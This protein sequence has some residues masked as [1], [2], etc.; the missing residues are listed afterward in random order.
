MY[1]DFLSY[2]HIEVVHEWPSVFSTHVKSGDYISFS[3]WEDSDKTLKSYTSKIKV[4]DE[5][6]E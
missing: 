6:K 3:F 1:I 5:C 4:Q 2:A